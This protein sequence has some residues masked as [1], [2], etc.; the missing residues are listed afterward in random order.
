MAVAPQQPSR[1]RL[2]SWALF[3]AAGSA[4]A[5]VGAW[6]VASL[7]LD[8]DVV[9][10]GQ[11]ALLGP[12]SAA[13]ATLLVFATSVAGVRRALREGRA[14]VAGALFTGI[15]AWLLLA[16]TALA[17]AAAAPGPADVTPLGV[18]AR[19]ALGPF[20]ILVAVIAAAANLLVAQLAAS[21]SAK[22][23]DGRLR[24]WYEEPPSD[25]AER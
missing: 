23:R 14:S 22:G 4:V 21:S 10:S 13:A 16:L 18:A 12:L 20:G 9:E 25:D 7:L 11:S 17:V 3:A 24:W 8:R 6:G 5:I 15:A 1:S 2:I 19:L